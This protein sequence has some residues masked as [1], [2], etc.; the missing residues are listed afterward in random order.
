[1]GRRAVKGEGT[2]GGHKATG[3][4]VIFAVLRTGPH[5]L[6]MAPSGDPMRREPWVRIVPADWCRAHFSRRRKRRRLRHEQL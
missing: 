1:M 3:L 5:W 4:P 6:A 2:E